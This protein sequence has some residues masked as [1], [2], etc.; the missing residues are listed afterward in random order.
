MTTIY[1]S[2]EYF[3]DVYL[4]VTKD[5]F[6]AREILHYAQRMLVKAK[7]VQNLDSALAISKALNLTRS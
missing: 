2:D 4:G 1:A 7:I 3:Q 5:S 6:T